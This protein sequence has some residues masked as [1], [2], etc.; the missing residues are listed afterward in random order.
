V[1]G[2]ILGHP[3]GSRK[4]AKEGAMVRTEVE[5]L[6]EKTAERQFLYEMET[7]FELAPAA[8]RAVLETAQQVFLASLGTCEVREGQQRVTVVSDHEPSGKPLTAMKK[9][10]VVVTVDSGMEDLEVLQRFGWEGLRRCRLLRMTE[11]AVDQGGV[12][13]QE[14]LSR[15][16]QTSVRTVRRDIVSL[17]ADGHWVPTRGT[18]QEIGRGQSHKAKIVE[19]YLQRMTYSEIVRRAHHAP[20]SVKRYVETFGRVVVLW[21]KGVRDL[22]EVAYVVSVSPRL[23]REYLVLRERYD[24]PAYRDRLE[25]IARQV[26]RALNGEGEEKRG[27]R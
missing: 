8:S 20:G 10:S 22:N 4:E 9:V 21:E 26:R 18:V 12:L 25:E 6:A 15:L 5:R 1:P 17:R 16:L 13:T 7:D 11:E 2:W 19:M 23:A 14:D 27:S 24:T 3:T